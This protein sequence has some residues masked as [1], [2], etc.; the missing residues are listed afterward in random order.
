MKWV[1]DA[2]A[3]N[4]VHQYYKSLIPILYT[5][6]PLNLFAPVKWLLFNITGLFRPFMRGPVGTKDLELIAVKSAAL[7]AE[8]LVLALTAQD[9]SSCM[10]EGF[11][12]SR[13]RRLLKLRRTTSIAM[14]IAVG[15]AAENAFW[16]PQFR[17]PLESTLTTWS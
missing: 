1:A 14:V 16:G 15:H 10:M 13:L 7:A 4:E 6:G 5:A 11:D 17:L 3:P 2:N 8:N 12:D 9:L